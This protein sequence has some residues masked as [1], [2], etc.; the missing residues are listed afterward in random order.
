MTRAVARA[1]ISV[2]VVLA[3]CGKE[4]QKDPD[5]TAPRIANPVNAG[6]GARDALRVLFTEAVTATAATSITVVS[7]AHGNVASDATLTRDGVLEV[8]P[9]SPLDVPDTITVTVFDVADLAGNVLVQGSAVF[10]TTGWADLG[11]DSGAVHGPSYV[12]H[13]EVARAAGVTQV[14]WPFGRAWLKDGMWTVADSSLYTQSIAARGGTVLRAGSAFGDVLMDQLDAETATTLGPALPA[15][16]PITLSLASCPDMSVL[17]IVAWHESVGSGASTYTRVRAAAHSL[18]GSWLD[19]GVLGGGPGIWAWNP[20]VACWVYGRAYVAF[21]QSEDGGVS[22]R[23]RVA[24]SLG[25][26]WTE[27]PRIPDNALHPTLAVGPNEEL[28][29]AYMDR[30]AGQDVRVQRRRPGEAWQPMGVP[31]TDPALLADDA[32]LFIHQGTPV[33]AWAEWPLDRPDQAH[34]Q[35]KRWTGQAWQTLG[36][37]PVNDEVPVRAARAP[38]LAID[39]D[40]VLVV[41]YL[42]WNGLGDPLDGQQTNHRIRVKRLLP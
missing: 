42:E 26:A 23:L 40:G 18:Y 3:A 15:S 39:D 28:F 25:G 9:H 6:V 14:V 4:K 20:A 21:E 31:D 12:P 38:R 29:I 11:F 1:A 27:L 5:L 36:A 22:S 41:A 2:M 17:A 7:R 37:G 19:L 8:T 34:I 13:P 33:V 10:E 35:V 32:S 30:G 16:S 24:E